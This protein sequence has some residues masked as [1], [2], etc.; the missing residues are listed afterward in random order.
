MSHLILNDMPV[1]LATLVEAVEAQQRKRKT[2]SLENIRC[3]CCDKFFAQKTSW[4][5]FCSPKCKTKY[6][7]EYTEQYIAD[8]QR[9]VARL[10][11]ENLRLEGECGR[12]E[13]EI[14]R[15]RRP[16]L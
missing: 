14:A 2:S 7:R 5:E 6:H 9:A 8:L 11:E 15:L 16:P 4:Q 3:K 12:L 10:K 13:A 1:S